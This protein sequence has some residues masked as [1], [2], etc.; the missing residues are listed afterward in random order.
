MW[1][2]F[3]CPL[4]TQNTLNAAAHPF[5]HE[6]FVKRAVKMFAFSVVSVNFIVLLI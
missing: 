4:P 1:Y 5:L 2:H 3:V 6:Y